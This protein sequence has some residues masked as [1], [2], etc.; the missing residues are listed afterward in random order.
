MK[1]ESKKSPLA[2]F[3]LEL[4]RYDPQ[5]KSCPHFNDCLVHMGSRADKVP[6]SKIRFDIVP[7][8]FQKD[9]YETDDP[10]AP[11]LQRLYVDCFSSVFHTHT[12]DNVFKY[13]TE[14]L[15]SARKVNCSLRMFLLAN[16]V[17][18]EIHQNEVITHTER[19]AKANFRPKLLTGQLAIDRAN[20][21]QELCTNRFGTFS[22][23]SL[24]ILSDDDKNTLDAPLLQSEITAGRK[25][26]SLKIHTSEPAEP[27]LYESEEIQLAPEWLALEETY[28]EHVLKKYIVSKTGTQVQQRH[29]F[30]VTQVLSY[31]KRYT[32]TAKHAWLT[33]QSI[34]PEAVRFVLSSFNYQ[35]DDFLYAREPVTDAMQFWTRLGLVIRHNHCLRFLA[36]DSSYYTPRRNYS[37][38]ND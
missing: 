35:P 9:V 4:D 24:S 10:E 37:Q 8:V 34:M 26:I 33:R 29:R 6:L 22:L 25:I 20:T 2:C 27:L 3:G 12:T 21:Y 7:E 36:G 31:Y 14:I 5:C 13:R 19:Q 16:M 38:Q 17:A 23:K 15:S 18:H 1:Q 28:S 11:H 30:A 32:N